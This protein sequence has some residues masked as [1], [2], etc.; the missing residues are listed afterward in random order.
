MWG[1]A[2]FLRRLGTLLFMIAAILIVYG[3][4]KL[5]T[6]SSSLSFRRVII[7]GQ[8]EHVTLDMAETAAKMSIKGNFF[9]QKLE[10]VQEAFGK[11]PWVKTVSVRR[12]WPDVLSVSI[13][14]H[15]LLARWG[16]S[17]LMD[18]EGILFQGATDAILPVL[19]GPDGTQLELKK[20]MEEF[21]PVLA[22]ADAAIDRLEL[23]KRYAWTLTLRT[24]ESIR[25]GREDKPGAVL[26]RL[27]Y[28][29]SAYP[30]LTKR[31]GNTISVVD[32]RYANGF[33]VTIKPVDH[34]QVVSAVE[35]ASVSG[36]S[37]G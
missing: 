7:D 1:D 28:F 4:W 22:K 29:V 5:L 25:L 34:N 8:T 3:G 6:S 36:E 15:D 13:T 14:E 9:G 2:L 30:K 26:E 17:A 11:L 35:G 32:M 33:S 19:A 37:Q 21:N 24:G 16:N 20:R 23:D 10:E 31:Y 18:K 12:I 27:T